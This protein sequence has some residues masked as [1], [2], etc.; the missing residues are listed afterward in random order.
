MRVLFSV[1]ETAGLETP[2]VPV[3]LGFIRLGHNALFLSYW[4]NDKAASLKFIPVQ[5]TLQGRIKAQTP[6][7]HINTPLAV[8]LGPVR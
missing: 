3:G 4:E 6:I 2:D 1:T 8:R 7:C 5:D